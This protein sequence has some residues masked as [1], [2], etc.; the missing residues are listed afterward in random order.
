MQNPIFSVGDLFIII[1]SFV[2]RG[3]V[4]F[5][6]HANFLCYP[7]FICITVSG[8]IHVFIVNEHRFEVIQNISQ[9]KRNSTFDFEPIALM[10]FPLEN[11]FVF[12]E[13]EK[14]IISNSDIKLWILKPFKT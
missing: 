8:S 6:N 9:V 10:W 5:L 14:K 1:F 4:L 12:V 2:E 11:K 7:R 13:R 3:R